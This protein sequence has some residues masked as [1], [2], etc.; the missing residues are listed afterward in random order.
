LVPIKGVIVVL[1]DF[2]GFLIAFTRVRPAMQL[3]VRLL[4][5]YV[6]TST[7]RVPYLASASCRF[8]VKA[9]RLIQRGRQ[10]D[11][12]RS[13]EVLALPV[14]AAASAVAETSVDAEAIVEWLGLDDN[15]LAAR[16]SYIGDV[17]GLMAIR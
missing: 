1:L 10:V 8:S 9:S 14:L 2:G 4:S 15:K 17:L 12:T 16:P 5:A 7:H 11:Q 3:D 13:R 6:L